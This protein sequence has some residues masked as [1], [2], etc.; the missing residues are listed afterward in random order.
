MKSKP[1]IKISFAILTLFLLIASPMLLGG[2][3]KNVSISTCLTIVRKSAHNYFDT[4]TDYTNYADTTI[5][6]SG[7]IELTSDAH[8]LVYD[9]NGEE[10]T[11]MFSDTMLVTVSSTLYIKNVGEDIAL[12]LEFNDDEFTTNY[13]VLEE[14]SN[15]TPG[16][17]IRTLQ[18]TKE[19]VKHV[20]KYVLTPIESETGFGYYIFK[21]E[22]EWVEDEDT[23]DADRAPTKTCYQYEDGNVTAQEAYINAVEKILFT[24]NDEV[25]IDTFFNLTNSNSISPLSNKIMSKYAKYEVDGNNLRIYTDKVNLFNIGHYSRYDIR[26][27][28]IEYE[29]KYKKNNVCSYTMKGLGYIMNST[30]DFSSRL[31]ISK[32]AN[33]DINVNLEDYELSP[34]FSIDD[35]ELPSNTVLNIMAG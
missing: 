17:I 3:A 18:E 21:E 32:K 12:V 10:V 13:S 31:N 29:I 19:L 1:K 34:K 14:A 24:I 28:C 26:D 16:S 33:V 4:R 30:A 15:D 35:K 27:Y 23:T 8:E 7:E 20:V 25:I 22:A 2:C 11:G 5:S 9:K 6:S